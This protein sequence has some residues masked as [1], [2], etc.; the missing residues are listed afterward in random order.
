MRLACGVSLATSP[1]ILISVAA[2]AHVLQ[3]RTR[4]ILH[5]A[6]T[7]RLDI[8]FPSVVSI[9]ASLVPTSPLPRD[10]SIYLCLYKAKAPHLSARSRLLLASADLAF[11]CV[12]LI[13]FTCLVYL[14]FPVY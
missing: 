11:F 5:H 3:P 6:R 8:R 4:Y 7:I 10:H 1:H 2:I 12:G 9:I 13:S 14:L